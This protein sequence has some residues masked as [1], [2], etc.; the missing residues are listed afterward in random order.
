MMPFLSTLPAKKTSLNKVSIFVARAER[1]FAFVE[2]HSL[3]NQPTF[4]DATLFYLRKDVWET[5]VE[6]PYCRC[7]TTQIWVV[8]LI[9]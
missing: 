6:I 4:C 3:G 8:F 5:N 7:V 1:S 2:F 9:G